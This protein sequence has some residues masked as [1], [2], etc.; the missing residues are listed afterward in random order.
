MLAALADG[1]RAKAAAAVLAH[2]APRDSER[3]AVEQWALGRKARPLMRFDERTIAHPTHNY[4]ASL[5]ASERGKLRITFLIERL[6]L[7]GGIIS[8]VQLAR[9]MMLL[10]H[11]VKFVTTAPEINPEYLNL[12]LQ[13]LVYRDHAHLIEAFPESDIVVATFWITAHLYM[14]ELR[15]RYPIVSVYFIQDY[16]AWFYPETDYENRRDVV[17]SYATTEHHIVKSRWLSELVARHGPSCD[18]V[19]LGLDL[20]VFYPR[21]NQRDGGPRVVSAALP[22]PEERRRGFPETVETFRRVHATRP[23]AE[24][25]FFGAHAK[26]MPDLPFPYTN[27]GRIDQQQVAELISSADVLLDASLW[28]AFGRP[29]LEAIACGAVPVLT[30]TGGLHEYAADRENC[31]L[32]PP[33]DIDAAASAILGLLD[34]RALRARL[35]AKGPATAAR[36]C[37]RAEAERHVALYR[38][39]IEEKRAT[40]PTVLRQSC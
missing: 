11:E 3:E 1:A 15:R 12:W 22:K 27:A 26:D 28:Q 6:S 5:P 8:V 32:V 13:P 39:W 20:G 30:N 40:I 9:E 23:D 2:R 21:A 24:L 19:P 37:H 34:D 18:I 25:I 16:E 10:G 31:L 4:I 38:R 36:F 7:C 29:G 33:A 17:R 35:Q 14:T